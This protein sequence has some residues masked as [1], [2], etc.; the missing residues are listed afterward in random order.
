MELKI[1]KTEKEYLNALA[2]ADEL[3]DT[4]PKK[5]SVL[6]NELEVLLLLI[7]IKT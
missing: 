1:I 3:F 5:N 6:G 2:R 7:K 4:K